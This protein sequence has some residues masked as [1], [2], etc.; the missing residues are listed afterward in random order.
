M[1][2]RGY[3]ISTTEHLYKA[4]YMFYPIEEG[5]D[6]EYKGDTWRSNVGYAN[7]IKEAKSEIDDIIFEK[8]EWSVKPVAHASGQVFTW[9]E[10]A[11]T[12]AV[13]INAVEFNYFNAI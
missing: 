7:S 1:E 6:C 10:D 11:I 8:T 5:I 13:K 2:Y 12:Y 9:L 3:T 4:V